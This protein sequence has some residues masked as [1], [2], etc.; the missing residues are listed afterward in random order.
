MAGNQEYGGHDF[1]FVDK[2]PDRFNCQICTKVLCDPHLAVCCGQHFCESCLNKWFDR[3]QGKQS[4]PHCRA[5]GEEFHHVIN[6]GLRSEINQLKIKCSNHREGCQW[7]GELGMLKG[8]LES[9][10]GCGFM[11]VECPNKCKSLTPKHGVTTTM[12]RK[13]LNDHLARWCYLRPHQ[14]G[15]C[16]LK[17]TYEAITGF[18]NPNIGPIP[19]FIYYGHEAKC[20]EVPLHCPNKCGSKD[21]KRKDM[22]GH[23]SKCPRELVECPFAEAGCNSAAL[24]CQLEDHITSSVQRHL[25][26][27]MKDNRET[28]VELRETRSTL[29]DT[30][31]EMN[32]ARAKLGETEAKLSEA[33]DRLSLLENL[34]DCTTK[35][36]NESDSIKIVMPKFSEY[37]RSGKVWHSPPFYYREGYKMCLAVYANGTG[38]GAGTHV[39]ISLLLLRGKYDDQLK[40]PMKFCE[41]REHYS[42]VIPYVGKWFVV[43]SDES[44]RPINEHKQLG[45]C[46]CFCGLTSEALRLVNDC[47]TLTVEF[48]NSC[49]LLVH[50]D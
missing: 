14:C 7:T 32:E 3:Q 43:C 16:G 12:Q 38:E 36:Q 49:S 31:R 17:G 24:R 4:C 15:F 20:P 50:F 42:F 27:V 6:K 13:H 40:W 39:S 22:D 35:L 18:Q 37:R 10:K 1:D 2:V 26:M 47:L 21:I 34:T 19:G 48:S 8:H 9:E 29:S 5:E 41:T 44:H 25:M 33:F 28:K 45:Q 46:E 30:Q 23:R 11:M